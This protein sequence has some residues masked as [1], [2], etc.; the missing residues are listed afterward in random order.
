MV[1]LTVATTL[2][3]CHGGYSRL[4]LDK[5]PTHTCIHIASHEHYHHFTGIYNEL[6]NPR[7]VMIELVSD[8]FDCSRD[9]K[10]EG[11]YRLIIGGTFAH[12]FALFPH[13]SF[14][15]FPQSQLTPLST[16]LHSI[17]S[18]SHSFLICHLAL[19]P[20][21]GRFFSIIFLPT[22][23]FT[24]LGDST[25]QQLCNEITFHLMIVPNKS[26]HWSLY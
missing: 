10:Q 24:E 23:G 21:I 7:D 17:G 8:I 26:L 11:Y 16:E 12:Y 6:I 2:A 19:A 20:S 1:V 9:F 18:F 3:G 15:G 4:L 14:C 5:K 22:R 25:Y 13:S